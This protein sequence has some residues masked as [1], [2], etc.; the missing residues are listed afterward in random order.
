MHINQV[1]EVFMLKIHR[2]L[3][4]RQHKNNELTIKIFES[5]RIAFF[6]APN[7]MFA[8]IQLDEWV[9]R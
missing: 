8:K 2:K 1:L 9:V 4:I 6:F 5:I 7:N 3:I